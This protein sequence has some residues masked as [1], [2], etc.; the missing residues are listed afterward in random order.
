MRILSRRSAV[1]L[2]VS[3]LL[4]GGTIAGRA[5]GFTAVP[6]KI[7]LPLEDAVVAYAR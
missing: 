6:A 2:P 1:R 3:V 4:H 7:D 5:E